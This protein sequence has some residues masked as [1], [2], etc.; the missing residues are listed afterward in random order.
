MRRSDRS[1]CRFLAQTGDLGRLLGGH[2][3]ITGRLKSSIAPE[4]RSRR[5]RSEAARAPG[6]QGCRGV[7]RP[8][9]RLERNL[10]V[11]VLHAGV[12]RRNESSPLAAQRLRISVPRHVSIALKFRGRHRQ[13][14]AASPKF[15][16]ASHR[17]GALR[18]RRDG[19]NRWSPTWRQVLKTNASA[20][21]DFF[22]WWRFHPRHRIPRPPIDERRGLLPRVS[23]D[24]DRRRHGQGHRR[25]SGA[26]R[27]L[28]TGR[29]ES[30][31]G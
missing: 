10:A 31:P 14:P 12:T 28:K 1:L 5:S 20:D 26:G 19:R 24:T 2:S 11:A 4:P 29:S 21:D 9:S 16:T 25:Q 3:Y 23:R 18:P 22:S 27:P 6:C 15:A 8:A 30:G 17:T 13:A 7:R